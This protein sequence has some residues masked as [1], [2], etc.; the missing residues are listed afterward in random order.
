ME[1]LLFYYKRLRTVHFGTCRV[2]FPNSIIFLLKQAP[3]F[4]FEFCDSNN[5]VQF[6]F[7]CPPKCTNHINS[8][9]SHTEFMN[10]FWGLPL[11]GWLDRNDMIFLFRSWFCHHILRILKLHRKYWT[12][13]EP[14][15]SLAIRYVSFWYELWSQTFLYNSILLTGLEINCTVRHFLCPWHWLLIRH[16]YDSNSI[17]D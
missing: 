17:T 10:R 12:A 9:T 15:D 13:L 3:L 16:R 14:C 11:A 2:L 1:F 7:H 4:P 6:S 5:P 8:H